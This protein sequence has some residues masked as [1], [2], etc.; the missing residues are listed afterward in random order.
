MLN[1]F[2]EYAKYMLKENKTGK[3]INFFNY[4]MFH[5]EKISVDTS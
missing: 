3:M 4:L 2:M 5:G 1:A